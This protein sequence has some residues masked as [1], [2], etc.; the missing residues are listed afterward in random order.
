MN[1]YADP[2]GYRTAIYRPGDE[3][4]LEL[5]ADM[6]RDFDAEDGRLPEGPKWT[7]WRGARP[8]GIGGVEPDGEGWFLTEDL[9]AR[10]WVAAVHA[11]RACLAWLRGRKMVRRVVA[12]VEPGHHAA[13]RMLA[14]LGFELDQVGHVPGRSWSM[15]WEAER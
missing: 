8:V 4:R 11:S 10:D 15:V 3:R 13:R 5:R 12:L 2:R 9:S 14:K 6:A 1:R 7:L